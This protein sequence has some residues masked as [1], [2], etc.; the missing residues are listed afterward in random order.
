LNG[1]A[2]LRDDIRQLL[3]DGRFTEPRSQLEFQ[4]SDGVLNVSRLHADGRQ[5]IEQVRQALSQRLRSRRVS[6]QLYAQIG[7]LGLDGLIQLDG[8][9]KLGDEVCKILTQSR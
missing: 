4:G 5:L 8:G 6:V 1:R 9:A 7:E 3:I 2:Q